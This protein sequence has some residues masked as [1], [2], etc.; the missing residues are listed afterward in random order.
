MCA[1]RK[2]LIIELDGPPFGRS[3]WN[4]QSTI[5]KEQII[6][7]LAVI[8]FPRF[9]NNDVIHDMEA[10]RKAIWS[11]LQEEKGLH[12][13]DRRWPREQACTLFS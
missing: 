12:N 7:K 1:P 9:W 5:M 4:R 11:V 3:T 2:K 8:V 13:V 10:V 6:G